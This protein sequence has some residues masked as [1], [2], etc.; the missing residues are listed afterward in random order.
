MGTVQ[1]CIPIHALDEIHALLAII[2]DLQIEIQPGLFQGFANQQNV[3]FCVF[4]Q[5]NMKARTAHARPSCIWITMML[6]YP[7][8]PV[9]LALSG[10]SAV[11]ASA[12][13]NSASR[14]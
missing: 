6:T 11:L 13:A 4:D 12:L 10:S 5:N 2:K 14:L 8:A 9:N 3:R 1:G 7:P